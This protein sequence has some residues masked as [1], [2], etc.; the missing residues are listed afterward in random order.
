MAH[1]IIGL[2]G[3]I[4][5]GKSAV[6]KILA[7]LGCVVASSD[8]DGRAA[9]CDP[10]IRDTLVR[11]WGRSVLD[12]DGAVDRSAVAAIVFSDPEERRRLEALTHPWIEARRRV[13]FDSAAPDAPALVIDAPLL[14]EA[15]LDDECDVVLFVDAP[16]DVRLARLRE[17]RGWDDDELTRREDSQLPLDVKRKR[18]DHVV[19]NDGDLSELTARVR[20]ILSETVESRRT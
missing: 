4:G 12:D 11:W 2:T 15:G 16:R 17:D 14:V 9:L 5:A 1:L 3:G 20:S 10:V 18:A 6:A 8:R 19:R 7:D 13:L